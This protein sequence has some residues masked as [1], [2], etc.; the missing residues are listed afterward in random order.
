MKQLQL[1]ITT[2]FLLFTILSS[3]SVSATYIGDTLPSSNQI[4][5]FY[6]AKDVTKPHR[7]IGHLSLNSTSTTDK[8]IK[9]T[10]IKKAKAIGADAIIIMAG[11]YTGN[12]DVNLIYQADAIKYTE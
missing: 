8:A 5:I 1:K 4:D 11:D 7:V 10:L 6:D 2:L 12:R 9:P 3:C